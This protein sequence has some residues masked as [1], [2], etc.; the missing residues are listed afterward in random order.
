MGV[1]KDAAVVMKLSNQSTRGIV[2]PSLEPLNPDSLPS[3]GRPTG[4][5]SLGYEWAGSFRADM[6]ALVE[7]AIRAL[8]ASSQSLPIRKFGLLP[9]LLGCSEFDIPAE[10]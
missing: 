10:A 5:V 1:W 8:N 2:K 4:S 7:T 6:R 3:G 9:G